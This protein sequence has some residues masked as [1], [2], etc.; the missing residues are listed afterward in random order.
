MRINR[1]TCFKMCF[2]FNHNWRPGGES[3][4]KLQ[5]GKWLGKIP[6]SGNL[7]YNWVSENSDRG[8]WASNWL[9]NRFVSMW[10]PW[11][12][13]R[14]FVVVGDHHYI[15]ISISFGCGDD[16]CGGWWWWWWWWMVAGEEGGGWWWWWWMVEGG[17][18]DDNDDDDDGGWWL[19]RVYIGKLKWNSLLLSPHP[20]CRPMTMMMMIWAIKTPLI[21]NNKK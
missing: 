2:N 16:D 15:V 17:G 6:N 5:K 14:N 20:S 8:G 9:F 11:S 1:D 4:V 7:E 10:L 18:D 19:V 12:R 3:N 13:I 21:R